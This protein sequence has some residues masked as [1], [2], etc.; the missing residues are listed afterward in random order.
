[1]RPLG[2]L[3]DLLIAERVVEAEHPLQV[4]DRGEVGGERATDPLRRRLG[5]AQVGIRLLE[6]LQLAHHPVVV[7][8]GHRRRVRDVVRELVTQD[9]VGQR[10]VLFA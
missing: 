7:G 8:V 2:P 9:F 6:R 5:R 3:G 10:A 4:V 1:V